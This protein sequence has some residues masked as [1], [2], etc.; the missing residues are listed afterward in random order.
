MVKKSAKGTPNK[1]EA[2]TMRVSPKLKYGLELLCRKQ[3]RTLTSVMEWALSKA[4]NDTNEGLFMDGHNL[5]ERLWEP[6]EPARLIRLA[7]DWHQLMTYEEEIIWKTICENAWYWTGETNYGEFIW[8]ARDEANLNT[9]RVRD[10]WEILKKIPEEQA[11]VS[12]LSQWW[13]MERKADWRRIIQ[14]STI[15]EF[16]R[17]KLTSSNLL[18]EDDIPF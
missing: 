1:A 10:D 8:D 6:D 17:K 18:T 9:Q 5:L 2:L 15:Q 4:L 16:A 3:H 14:D 7:Y 13:P 11:S 12:D